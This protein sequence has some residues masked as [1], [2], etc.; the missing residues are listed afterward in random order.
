[1]VADYRALREAFRIA[2][3][4]S[5]KSPTLAHLQ[6][7]IDFIEQLREANQDRGELIAF[8]LQHHTA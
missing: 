8:L 1:M 5:R 4:H 7:L 2:D 6:A 3:G